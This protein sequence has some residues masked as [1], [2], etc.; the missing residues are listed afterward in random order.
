MQ[1]D[2]A[3]STDPSFGTYIVDKLASETVRAPANGSEAFTSSYEYETTGGYRGFLKSQAIRGIVTTYTSDTVLDKPT[4][5]VKT[6]EDGNHHVTSYAYVFGVAREIKTP[7]YTITRVINDDGTIASETRQPC[8]ISSSSRIV[9][10]LIDSPPFDSI[11]VRGTASVRRWSGTHSRR[12]F[13]W[14]V[15][16]LSA[17]GFFHASHISRMPSARASSVA[18]A[19][20]AGQAGYWWRGVQVSLWPFFH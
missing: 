15:M 18:P 3:C 4:G 11:I 20:K 7:L 9:I 6:A 14:P 19:R 13:R 10:P 17:G 12:W 1:Y 8:R 2:P 5:N 16:L